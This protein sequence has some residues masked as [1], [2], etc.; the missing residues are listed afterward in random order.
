LIHGGDYS[1]TGTKEQ[2][3]KFMEW[4]TTQSYEH[5]IFISGNHEVAVETEYYVRTGAQSFHFKQMKDASFDATKYSEECREIINAPGATYL[6]D[7]SCV[8]EFPST[9]T[10]ESTTQPNS[11]SFSFYGSPWSPEFCDWAFNAERGEQSRAIWS[12]IP[13]DVDILIT[14]GPPHGILD[15]VPR[16]K[17]HC[18]CEELLKVVKERVKP[19]LHIF[20]HIHETYG[21][22]TNTNLSHLFIIIPFTVIC[23]LTH[24]FPVTF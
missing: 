17:E 6:E 18:G 7:S 21:K 13:D 11:H 9:A 2:I 8:V 14:H 19:R 1:S 20:G 12:K 5:K 4:F 3:A 23:I 24:H 15:Y 16:S 10:T 22:F